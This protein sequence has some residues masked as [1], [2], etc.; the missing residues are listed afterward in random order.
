MDSGNGSR[1]IT[2]EDIAPLERKRSVADEVYEK[3]L[4][5]LIFSKLPAET[6]ISI[7]AM[8]RNLGVSQTPTRAA[9]FRLEEQGLVIR[10]HNRGFFVAPLYS[11]PRYSDLYDFRALVEPEMA[12]KAARSI[13]KP[14]MAELVALKKTMENRLENAKPDVEYSRFALDDNAFHRWII[15]HG[16]NAIILETFDRLH[17]HTHLFRLRYHSEVTNEA[18]KEHALIVDALLNR[19]PDAARAA[20]AHHINQSRLRMEPHFQNLPG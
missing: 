17:V 15:D 7:D 16:K 14:A 20:M 11:A 12:S 3:L 4:A 19:D 2:L 18:L 6:R 8:S 10:D 13:D 9:L 5:L 1:A